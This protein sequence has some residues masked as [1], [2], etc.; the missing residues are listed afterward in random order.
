MTI[1][2]GF[3]GAGNMGSAIMKGIS[4]SSVDAELF[5]FDPD[6]SKVETLSEYGVKSCSSETKLFS[7]CK[8]V[9]LAVKP[10][11]IEGVLETASSA[12]TA[13]TVLI[14]IAAGIND[15]FIAGKTR[16]DAKVILVMPNTPL[17]LGEGASALSHNDNVTEE[18]F[19]TVLNIF[20][21][22]GKA[23]VISKDKMKEVIALNGSSPAFI[24]L[25]AK[26]FI[27]YADKVGI[28]RNSATELFTQSLIGSAKMITDSGYTIDELIKMVS[29]PGGTTLAG[30]DRLYEGNLTGIVDNCCESCTKR[31]YELS[32]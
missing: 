11:I 26:G 28:D 2:I 16:S 23:V 7:E 3:I 27:D 8:Y 18:E 32:K 30:L 5:A 13:E 31:A 29:S 19:E 21:L 1:K 14:S 20:R 10:Q 17:L 22:C 25:F 12:V 9:F 4:K 24:Y 6:I 15:E